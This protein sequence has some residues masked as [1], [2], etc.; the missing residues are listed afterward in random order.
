MKSKKKN[1][2]FVFK[3]KNVHPIKPIP[4]C[5]MKFEIYAQLRIRNKAKVN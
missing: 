5:L 2:H 3:G 4:K 1:V